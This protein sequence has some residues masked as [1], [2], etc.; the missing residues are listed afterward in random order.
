VVR[1]DRRF[2]A[3]PWAYVLDDDGVEEAEVEVFRCAYY[4]V[5]VVPPARDGGPQRR[6]PICEYQMEEM[7]AAVE[8]AR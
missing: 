8:D 5:H 4:Q 7:R 1:V 2:E 6:C 3:T